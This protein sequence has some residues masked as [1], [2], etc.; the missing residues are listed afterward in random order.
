MQTSAAESDRSK[1]P[2]PRT[3]VFILCS[4]VFLHAVVILGNTVSA[5]V[6]IFMG[7]L[8]SPAPAWAAAF[9]AVTFLVWSATSSNY[10]CPATLLENRMRRRLGWSPIGNFLGHYVQDAI[11]R[12]VK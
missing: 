3:T 2:L 4:I 6:L 8:G 11:D 9:P 1:H 7:L 12:M 5:L 10:S